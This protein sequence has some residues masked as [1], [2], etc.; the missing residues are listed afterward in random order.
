MVLTSIEQ[1]STVC[2]QLKCSDKLVIVWIRLKFYTGD[3]ER[4]GNTLLS[5]RPLFGDRNPA[6]G[7]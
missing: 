5:Y 1:Q 6:V 4:I 3:V 2:A 7:D